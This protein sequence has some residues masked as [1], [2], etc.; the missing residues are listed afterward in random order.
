MPKKVLLPIKGGGFSTAGSNNGWSLITN[1]NLHT[2]ADD[3]IGKPSSDDHAIPSLIAHL[4]HFR[5][6][7]NNGDIDA[8]NEWRGMLAVIALQL[9]KS[10]SITIK[11]IP[12]YPDPVTGNPTS[13][14]TVLFDELYSN[15]DITGYDYEKDANGDYILQNN[16]KIPK[17]KTLSVF[18]LDNIPFAMFMPSMLICPFKA[19]PA[20]LFSN[21]DW[22]DGSNIIN[23]PNDDE[24]G[25]WK[26][27]LDFLQ[28]DKNTMPVTAQKFFLW[29]DNLYNNHREINP[30]KDFKEALLLHTYQKPDSTP[31][32]DPININYTGGEYVFD[33]LKT[34]CPFKRYPG[35]A[36][37]DNLLLVIPQNNLYTGVTDDGRDFRVCNEPSDGMIGTPKEIKIDNNPVFVIPPFHD[38]VIRSLRDGEASLTDWKV[39][40]E[41]EDFVCS[42]ELN[43]RMDGKALYFKRFSKAEIAY[44]ECMPYISMW[45]FVNFADDSWK[46][47]Y[48]ALV[49]NNYGLGASHLESKYKKLTNNRYTHLLGKADNS[50]KTSEI[51]ISL[52]AKN[53]NAVIDSY[54]CL[55][56]YS[57][58]GTSKAQE[59]K[60][61]SSNSEPYALEF[62]YLNM[63]S[64]KTLTLGCWVINRRDAEKVNKGT[65]K[66]YIAMDFGSTSTNIYLS[67]S[68]GTKSISSPGKY[69]HE[70]YNPYVSCSAN[71]EIVSATSDFLQNYYL[72]SSRKNELGKI[73]TYGQNFKAEK[74]D[75]D[76]ETTVSNASGR[77]IVVDK[78]FLFDS[79]SSNTNAVIGEKS[80]IWNG[81]KLKDGNDFID[82]RQKATNNF[83]CNSLTYAVLEAKANGANKV[84]IRVSYPSEK[85]CSA[86]LESVTSFESILHSKSGLAVDIKGTTEARA[87]GEYFANGGRFAAG[88]G[89][90]PESG[91]AIID[92]GGGTTDFSFWKG[93]PVEMRAE[94]SFGYAGNYLV[95]RTI[96]QGI[97][98]KNDFESLW[99][100]KNSY[101]KAFDR[102]D[103]FTVNKPIP[104]KPD[105]NYFQK[106]AIIDYLLENNS[107]A[108]DSQTLQEEQYG[109]F[110]SAIRMKYYALFYLI[111]S[112]MKK[113][114]DKGNI[115]LDEQ[116]LRICL[117]G[118]GSKGM[119]LAEVGMSDRFKN[120][121]KTIFEKVLGLPK[122][123]FSFGMISTEN[124]NKEEVVIGLTLL[125]GDEMKTI[126]GIV[127]PDD[128]GGMDDLDLALAALDGEEGINNKPD[129]PNKKDN[130]D[131]AP[132]ES[133]DLSL[134]ELKKAYERLVVF[135][136]VF[137]K[138]SPLV[139][140]INLRANANADT[141]YTNTVKDIK[142]QLKKSNPNHDTYAENFA[143]LMLENMINNFI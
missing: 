45:P 4:K 52:V 51:K 140:L 7:L 97:Q 44:T 20:N 121:I 47:H 134:E 104:L 30:I 79:K 93:D 142:S 28:Y 22:Y 103:S 10:L 107:I 35:G 114:I 46:E 118:C 33:E 94:Y 108:Y 21:L 62:S 16:A 43:F 11:D 63:T 77:M 133:F 84:E 59:I 110:F 105:E 3:I 6:K 71:G 135:L 24:K 70:I 72:F 19:Y 5:H 122:N 129:E 26:S 113:E 49:A 111:A 27:V 67:D 58:S 75:D 83:I 38:D 123:G 119:D 116:N 15:S 48:V 54:K 69:L 96:I 80:G 41:G 101:Q 115:K 8:I 99:K 82:E 50:G 112:Y 25:K 1:G 90:D 102:Y 36:F 124:D 106:I 127:Q 120:N 13:L 73:F 95:E 98:N 138:G 88:E 17:Y 76:L 131:T 23:K 60:L 81:L 39:I 18:C 64:Q 53:K 91:Y 34:V 137:E 68:N 125:N 66:A 2:I 128:N 74:N 130:S 56:N 100:Q 117:A 12:I 85:Y 29:L 14:G 31:L 89:P 9:V 143:L 92:I 141:C 139:N 87:A 37:S 136:S 65:A 78:D 55:S 61:L 126:N 132:V 57:E 42:L 32:L 86:V 109:K 40:E